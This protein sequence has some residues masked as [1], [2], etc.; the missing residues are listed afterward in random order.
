MRF[1]VSLRIID[2]DVKFLIIQSNEINSPQSACSVHLGLFYFPLLLRFTVSVVG[3]FRPRLRPTVIRPGRSLNCCQSSCCP[4][5]GSLSRTVNLVTFQQSSILFS[6][7][8]STFVCVCRTT[9]MYFNGIGNDCS[10]ST[11]N[12]LGS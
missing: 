4:S 8:L 10:R 7:R 1:L 6:C 3:H 12:F 5:G 11:Y 2:D 9:S